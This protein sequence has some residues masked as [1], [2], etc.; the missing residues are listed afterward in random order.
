[1]ALRALLKGIT[2]D[3]LLS[4]PFMSAGFTGVLVCGHYVFL[5]LASYGDP[6]GSP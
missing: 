2:L 6:A 1:M 3:G 4:F 5:F